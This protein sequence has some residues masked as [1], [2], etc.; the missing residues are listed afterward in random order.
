MDSKQINSFQIKPAKRIGFHYFPDTLHYR[1]NDLETWLPHLNELGASWL[2]IRSSVE[3]AIPEQF[4]TGLV[5]SGIE[6]IIWF[7]FPLNKSP[8]LVEIKP[9][10][11]SYARWGAN[12]IA[13]FDQPNAAASWTPSMWSQNSIV[14][15]FLERFLPLVSI[16]LQIGLKPVLPPLQPGG[17]F[18]DT[19]F[20]R[21]ML[22]SLDRRKLTPV[23]NNM[24]LSAYACTAGRDL[25]WGAGGPERWPNSRPYITPDGE[26][27]QCGFRIFDWYKAIC[28]AV[29][30]TTIPIF[31]FGVG[32]EAIQPQA[33]IDPARHS[34]V[35]LAIARALSESQVPNPDK[36]STFLESIPE[37][38]LASNF[39]LLAAE[40]DTPHHAQAWFQD[41][42]QLPVV[43][44]LKNW[45]S[46]PKI[47][48]KTPKKVETS[49]IPCMVDFFKKD[50]PFP[51]HH[52]IEHYLL[53]PSFK[54]GAS[55]W[56]FELVKPFITKYRPTI[57]F[58]PEEA[59]LAA[60]V[61]IVGEPRLFP[62]GTIPRLQQAGCKIERIYVNGTSVAP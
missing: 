44:N 3:R 21:S 16:T 12:Y 57:G 15:R 48:A 14:D 34:D 27:D 1:S 29:I 51:V 8:N 19:V 24:A 20:L 32:V 35:N 41:G 37:E 38:V 59:E 18:W 40:K 61:T 4:V 11:T 45:V 53:L 26:Q 49:D 30:G 25:Q 10:L 47:A 9:I 28:Q 13:F 39:W 52:K 36:S 56:Q 5:R 33:Q 60:K 62:E 2:V 31:L 55:D 17:S 46:N 6:P 43:D 54:N 7:D 22:E 42:K 23:V 50:T 58:S